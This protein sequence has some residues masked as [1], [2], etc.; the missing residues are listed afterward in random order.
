MLCSSCGTSFEGQVCP[1][2]GSPSGAAGPASGMVSTFAAAGAGSLVALRCAGYLI[3]MMPAIV[4][5]VVLALVPVSGSML[6]GVIMVAYW[7]F[8]DITGA[9]PGKMLLGLRV[10]RKDG[11]ESV[12]R[13]R[14][15]RNVTLIVG[16]VLIL[17]PFGGF[18]VGPSITLGILAIELFFLITRKQRVGDILAG[19]AVVQ[20]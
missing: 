1:K 14:I 7:L 4:L 6:T 15:L 16:P 11:G 5:A 3:D 10:V 2:C 18:I 17:I 20:K 8:R 12:A 13:D 9:S 19:T